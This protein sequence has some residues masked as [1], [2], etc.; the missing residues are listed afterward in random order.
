MP[1]CNR[2]GLSN[3]I[4]PLLHG[5]VPLMW[6]SQCPI[7]DI[8]VSMVSTLSVEFRQVDA[9]AVRYTT[10]GSILA[11]ESDRYNCVMTNTKIN[12]N[13]LRIFPYQ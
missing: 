3:N 13:Y 5:K 2:H 1:I 8:T 12:A 4:S 10:P 11:L 7:S 9:S 6:Q